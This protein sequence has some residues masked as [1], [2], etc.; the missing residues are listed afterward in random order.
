MNQIK[1]I[2]KVSFTF[3]FCHS[4]NLNKLFLYWNFSSN[5]VKR[6]LLKSK[7]MDFKQQQGFRVWSSKCEV[8]IQEC[9]RQV[10]DIK[11]KYLNIPLFEGR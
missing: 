1:V 5:Y 7:F 10:G 6:I 2:Q 8:V 4:R 3:D 9:V 11:V